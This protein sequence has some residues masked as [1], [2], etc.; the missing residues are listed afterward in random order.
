[1]ANFYTSDH[2]FWHR[3]ILSYQPERAR[4]WRTLEEMHEGLIR[5]W[6]SVVGE[7]DE[8]FVLGDFC[9]GGVEKTKDIL[10]QL[11]GKKHLVIGNHD[12]NSVL[13]KA[14]SAGFD[15]VQHSLKWDVRGVPV[16]LSHYPYA[17]DHTSEERFRHRRPVNEGRW[18]LHGH[19]HSLWRVKNRQLNVGVDV[20]GFK[21][22]SESEILNEMR[23]HA[24]NIPSYT[25][26]VIARSK[27]FFRRLFK[28]T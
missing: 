20:W 16:V 3:N 27:A 14:Q 15:S 7:R 9:F 8:V 25:A 6:N 5:N 1:M 26:S 22:I 17:G 24:S 13:R 23:G 10:Q 12:F 28:G 21:P 19:V 11:N 4:K 2:H 18:L